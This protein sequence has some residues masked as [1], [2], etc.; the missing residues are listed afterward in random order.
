MNPDCSPRQVQEAIEK[1]KSRRSNSQKLSLSLFFSPAS[2][3][4]LCTAR[5]A[6]STEASPSVS[7]ASA[8]AW[9]RLASRRWRSAASSRR[10]SK[11]V[12]VDGPDVVVAPVA[13]RAQ[14]QL[15]LVASSPHV[16]GA[17]VAI[18]GP[19]PFAA[20]AFRRE[21]LRS[22]GRRFPSMFAS[23]SRSENW[24]TKKMRERFEVFF[25][26]FASFVLSC[27]YRNRLTAVATLAAEHTPS[28][29]SVA[30]PRAAPP[31]SA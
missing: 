25:S 11:S 17:P 12:V 13:P 10:A 21:R 31:P 8:R 1:T 24:E 22:G 3:S 27:F 6:A 7:A 19:V 4:S 14:M 15:L 28:T 16:A 26:A 18:P 5:S 20:A 29:P 2:R 23:L 9:A 30:G